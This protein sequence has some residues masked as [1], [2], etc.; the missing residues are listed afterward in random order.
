M[1]VKSKKNSQKGG[2]NDR[3]RGLPEEGAFEEGEEG[4]FEGE[5]GAFE[6]EDVS[7]I[8]SPDPKKKRGYDANQEILQLLEGDTHYVRELTQS[9]NPNPEQAKEDDKFAQEL[10]EVARIGTYQK[11]FIEFASVMERAAFHNLQIAHS[12]SIGV[13]RF[14]KGLGI[15]TGEAI[16]KVLGFLVSSGMKYGKMALIYLRTIGLENLTAA[17]ASMARV[18]RTISAAAGRPIPELVAVLRDEGGN[19]PGLA[20]TVRL[21]NA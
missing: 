1:V 3:K 15:V 21:V 11:R 19:L 20:M 16:G 5:E 13:S 14:I 4:A 17:R 7:G 10:V 12:G 2:A 9:P 6:G 18:Y 8:Q